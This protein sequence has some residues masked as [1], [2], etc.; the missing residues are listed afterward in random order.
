MEELQFTPIHY[1]VLGRSSRML[2][3][4]LQERPKLLNAPDRLGRTP[5]H[6]TIYQR[7]LEAMETLLHWGADISLED[8]TG[9]NIFH[10]VANDT[11]KGLDMFSVITRYIQPGV[12]GMER[13]R[14]LL[15]AQNSIG[16]T[17]LLSALYSDQTALVEHLLDYAPDTSKKTF[18]GSTL[19]HMATTFASTQTLLTLCSIDLS[20]VDLLVVEFCGTSAMDYAVARVSGNSYWACCPPHS[21]E[22]TISVVKL[23]AHARRFEPRL[24]R[25]LYGCKSMKGG[26]HVGWGLFYTATE[27]SK[28]E[29]EWD[30]WED[31]EVWVSE[32]G[33]LGFLDIWE[34]PVV[35]AE[36]GDEMSG[37]CDELSEQEM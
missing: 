32:H 10:Q 4:E 21:P 3:E 17:P 14:S 31:V 20:A 19:F 8:C 34:Y 18:F 25:L 5:L 27:S 35:V 2:E 6:W 15:N 22:D 29:D 12:A 13:V 1:I 33:D 37:E 24:P 9:N 16:G 28:I 11:Y 36:D 23:V 7:N 30:D 26:Y